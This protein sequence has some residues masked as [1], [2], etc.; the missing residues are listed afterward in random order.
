MPNK[1]LSKNINN[2]RS[3]TKYDTSNQKITDL[4]GTN[5]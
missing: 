3:F 2:C 4:F 1:I 5:E